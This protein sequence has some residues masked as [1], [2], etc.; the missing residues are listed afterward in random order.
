M[1]SEAGAKD[2]GLLKSCNYGEK[3]LGYI[4]NGI[5]YYRWNEDGSSRDTGTKKTVAS[6][7]QKKHR[8]MGGKCRGRSWRWWKMV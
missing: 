4:Y 3:S 5:I 6:E 1:I 2:T 7:A 8:T